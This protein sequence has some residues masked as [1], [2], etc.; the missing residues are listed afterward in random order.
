MRLN[1]PDVSRRTCEAWQ[2]PPFTPPLT[3]TARL[4]AAL[5]RVLDLQAASL[6]RDLVVLLPPCHGTVLDVGCGAQPYRGLFGAGVKY[7]GIDHA[8]VKERFGY[9]VPGT[10]YFSGKE[11]PV[12][13]G[14]AD[15]I[16][17][18]EVLE[19][20]LEPEGCLAE[21]FRCL[22]PGGQLLLTIPFAARWHYVPFDYWRFTPSGLAHL[23][24]KAGFTDVAVYPRGNAL[25]VACYKCLALLL[26][27]LV[28]QNQGLLRGLGMRLAGLLSLPLVL[29]LAG[30]AHLSLRGAGGD[31]CLGHTALARKDVRPTA[32]A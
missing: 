24:T 16:L 10:L 21:A 26:R 32:H 14:T 7:V 25:T 17:M 1:R 15:V 30:T 9:E 23:L 13:D 8:E 28:P 5:R 29:V 11:W 6:W 22:R 31:D 27:F 18:S 20:V 12:A 19:H 3:R 4:K 2:P